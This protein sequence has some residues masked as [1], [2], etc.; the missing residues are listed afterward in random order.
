VEAAGWGEF[1]P[2]AILAIYSQGK[3]AL[4]PASFVIVLLTGLLGL[5]GTYLW[6]QFADQNK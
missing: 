3:D 1:F 6:W 5:V 2:W 4:P